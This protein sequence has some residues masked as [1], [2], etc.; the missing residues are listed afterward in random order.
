MPTRA[1]CARIQQ[2]AVELNAAYGPQQWWPAETRF[3]VLLG[4]I[5]TQNTAWTHVEKAL[6]QL[7]QVIALEPEPILAL[8]REALAQAIRPA[9]YFNQKAA[10]IH[11]F[12]AWFLEHGG[13]TA[14]DQIETQAL[15]EALLAVHG[16][17][18]ETADDMML[19]AFERPVFVVDAYTHRLLQRYLKAPPPQDY[20][21][22]RG[23]VE[24][25]FAALETPTRVKTFNELHA[26][27]VR[28]AKVACTKR[29]PDCGSCAIQ[30]DCC[31]RL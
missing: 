5:L 20:E 13:F 27:I 4:A 29:N 17:G 3:E 9:G 22:V 24:E 31:Q 30:K 8:S 18:P 11:G 12:C 26:Q 21:T 15:R 23:W 25:A 10:R 6:D 1:Q 14:F 7:R 28:H 2:L 16:I 19:Y